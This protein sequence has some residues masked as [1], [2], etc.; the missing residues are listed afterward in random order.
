MAPEKGASPDQPDGELAFQRLRK[1]LF[2][3]SILPGFKMRRED[4]LFVIG[5]FFARGIEGALLGRK[6]EVL[7]AAPEFASFQPATKDLTGLGCTNKYNTYSIYNE[8]RWALDR[9]ELRADRNVGGRF[10][11]CARQSGRPHHADFFRELS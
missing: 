4:K 10:A 3:P 1:S 6:M 2:T 5:S 7:S 9:P 11:A 8:L